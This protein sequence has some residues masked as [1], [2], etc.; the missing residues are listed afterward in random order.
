MAT[1]GATITWLG[2]AATKIDTPGGKSILID[3]WLEHNPATPS[4]RQTLDSLDL[5]LITHGHA[6]HMGDA[7]Q[8][9]NAT[10]PDVICMVEIAGYMASHGVQKTN[11]INLGGTVAWNEIT[12]TMVNALHSSGMS[13][14]DQTVYGGVAAGYVIRLENGLTIYHAGDTDVFSDMRLIG[15]MHSP[16]VALLPIGGHYTMGPKGAAVA[17][18]ML[19]AGVVI[20]IHFGTF[21]ALTG[22]PDQLKKEIGP[23]GVYVSLRSSRERASRKATLCSWR[24]RA[25]HQRWMKIGRC[26]RPTALGVANPL[27]S[28]AEGGCRHH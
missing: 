13:D 28:L 11:G 17:A 19:G 5:M 26:T 27:C 10:K 21:P 20:P 4:N 9:A 3:P 24:C 22:T 12:I 23:D 14:G 6:D 2:H 18:R 8:I 1:D 15:E 16:D 7:V 25:R